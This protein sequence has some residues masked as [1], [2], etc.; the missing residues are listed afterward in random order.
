MKKVLFILAV[1]LLVSLTSI[2]Q[3]DSRDSVVVKKAPSSC[4]DFGVGFIPKSDY[5][6]FK[7]SVSVNNFVFKRFG[8]YTSFEA[9]SN[10][11]YFS[12]ILGITVSVCSFAYFSAGMDFFTKYGL[13]KNVGDG[14]RKEI[15]VGFYP[16]KWTTVKVGYSKSVGPSFQIGAR[17]PLGAK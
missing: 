13:F 6:A 16:W 3:S 10:K 15:G 5:E 9:N 12:H 11:D 4:I 8:L 2:A 7:A 17:F 1:G 14:N